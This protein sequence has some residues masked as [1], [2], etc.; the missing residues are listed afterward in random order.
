MM[1]YTMIADPDIPL[2]PGNKGLFTFTALT[3]SGDQIHPNSSLSDTIPV[4]STEIVGTYTGE[5]VV[6]L[7]EKP[8]GLSAATIETD[9]GRLIHIEVIISQYL[10]YPWH[11]FHSHIPY[12]HLIPIAVQERGRRPIPGQPGPP[13]LPP[14]AQEHHL[15]GQE[16]PGGRGPYP[17]KL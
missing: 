3:P 4:L 15:R 11:I 5:I 9:D 7:E 14:A 12:I 13:P 1:Q 16:L 10:I 6:E 8:E 2:P 17:S